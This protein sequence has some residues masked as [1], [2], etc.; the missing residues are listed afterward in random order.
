MPNGVRRVSR[1]VRYAVAF[2][3]SG[4]ARRRAR[5]GPSSVA[6]MADHPRGTRSWNSV[7]GGQAFGAEGPVCSTKTDFVRPLAPSTSST[8]AVTTSD[9]TRLRVVGERVRRTPGLGPSWNQ[10]PVFDERGQVPS[11]AFPRAASSTW[12]RAMPRAAEIRGRDR[13]ARLVWVVRVGAAGVSRAGL[14]GLCRAAPLFTFSADRDVV[15][16]E[17]PGAGV[18]RRQPGPA[19]SA[20]CIHSASRNGSPVGSSTG[21][22]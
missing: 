16:E 7:A 3:H 10:Q 4:R 1:R 20:T 6:W 9:W 5:E 21:S 19:R 14:G 8:T 12:Y 13:W 17:V 2:A 18:A 11:A 22:L 15:D